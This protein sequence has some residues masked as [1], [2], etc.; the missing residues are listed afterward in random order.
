MGG[1][2]ALALAGCAC[3]V[4]GAWWALPGP[5]EASAGVPEWAGPAAGGERADLRL[6]EPDAI[7]RAEATLAPEAVGIQPHPVEVASMPEP[8]LAPG[9]EAILGWVDD[10]ADDERRYNAH[11]AVNRLSGCGR[12][13]LPA[14]ELALHSPDW[15]QAHLA[16]HVLAVRGDGSPSP[17]LARLLVESLG[18]PD[19]TLT[20]RRIGSG[21]ER[22]DASNWFP[23]DTAALERLS[24]DRV[25]F[26][27]AESAV[28]SLLWSASHWER[29]DAALILGRQ[30]SDRARERALGLLV[31]HLADNEIGG[32]AG[33]A[34]RALASYG[35]SA[36]PCLARSCLSFD[37]QERSL[38]AHVLSHVDPEHALARR[39][40]PHDLRRMGF[41]AACDWVVVELERARH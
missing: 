10:L 39:L 20:S 18:P 4:A 13:A 41:P 12:E 30:R 26:R 21:P 6:A 35:K 27:Y 25:L 31:E 32:D 14:L 1:K 5:G 9:P 33:Q 17:T 29:I 36:V 2:L 24:T 16:A 28:A 19:P 11:E 8:E 23:L 37:E 40:T 7:A 3:S 15:Q 34:M 38:A 22:E